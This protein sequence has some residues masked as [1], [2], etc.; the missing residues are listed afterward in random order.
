[1]TGESGVTETLAPASSKAVGNVGE[2][3]KL[4]HRESVGGWRWL[5]H[6]AW[7]VILVLAVRYRF[8][9]PAMPA[10]DEDT[11]GFLNPALQALLGNGFQHTEGRNFLYPAIVGLLMKVFGDL[12]AVT[13]FQGTCSLATGALLL[14]NWRAL[15]RTV[16]GS[17]WRRIL[18]DVAGLAV[19]SVFLFSPYPIYLEHFIRADNLCPVLSLLSLWLLIVFLK[20]RRANPAGGRARILGGLL[21]VVLFTIPSLKPSYTLTAVLVA[22]PVWLAVFDRRIRPV[23]RLAMIGIPFVCIWLGLLWPERVLKRSDPFAETF[24]PESIFSIHAGIIRE[25]MSE[26]IAAGGSGIPYSI[27]QL[28]GIRTLLDD[29]LARARIR[30]SRNFSLLGFDADYLLYD[31]PF[32]SKLAGALGTRQAAYDFCH[33]YY[34]RVWRKHPA[35]MFRKIGGQLGVFYNL[36]C[37]V[38]TAGR[39]NLQNYYAHSLKILGFHLDQRALLESL[40]ATRRYVEAQE[41]LKATPA[42]LNSSR[43]IK[44]AEAILAA[45]CLPVFLATFVAAVWVALRPER[46]RQYGLVIVVLLLAYAFNAGNNLGIAILHSLEVVRYTRIQLATTLFAQCGSIALFACLLADLVKAVSASRSAGR[47]E[48]ASL[49]STSN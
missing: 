15:W 3:V 24:L 9:V 28:A 31:D 23:A 36:N 20:E 33:Y 8:S 41:S 29:G 25:Q 4:S 45:T 42:A 46:R 2:P 18:L 1:M 7:I 17:P 26:D 11:W 47:I 30:I 10:F 38:Y 16:G 22:M 40:P 49:H 32:F 37:P 43:Y 12:R 44:K 6:A 27:A 48:G 35:A 13:I 39:F 34:Q 14:I 19:F 21:V 5:F